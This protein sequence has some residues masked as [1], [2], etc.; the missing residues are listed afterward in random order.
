MHA[1][2]FSV[3]SCHMYYV[4]FSYSLWYIYNY[5]IHDCHIWT[6]FSGLIK[7]LH[8]LN[9]S[10][11]PLEFPPKDVL[12]KGTSEVLKFLRDMLQAKSAGK[13][14]NGGTVYHGLYSYGCRYKYHC[15]QGKVIGS[16]LLCFE[17]ML[18]PYS[19]VFMVLNCIVR[20]VWN[21]GLG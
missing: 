20:L 9:I 19:V 13:L 2:L 1:V 10:N 11:N 16:N 7:S 6:I 15:C 4:Y 12:E 17:F 3:T 8:G 14:L 21:E 18:D 5:N